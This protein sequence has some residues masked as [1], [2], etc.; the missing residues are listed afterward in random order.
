MSSLLHYR[1]GFNVGP[2]TTSLKKLPT[3]FGAKTTAG[4]TFGTATN[5]GTSSGFGFGTTTNSTATNL[6]KPSFGMFGATQAQAAPGQQPQQDDAQVI[7]QAQATAIAAPQIFND[8]RDELI[9]KWNQMQAFFGTGKAFYGPGG[10]NNIDFGPDNPWCRF[11]AVNYAR[12]SQYSNA[13][14][15]V[16][17]TFNKKESDIKQHQQQ[18]VDSIHKILGG[19]AAHSVCVSSIKPLP[20]D[21]TDM[22][23]FVQERNQAGDSRKIPASELNNFFQ[24]SSAKQQLTNQLCVCNIIAKRRWSKNELKAYLEKPIAGLDPLLWQQA[25]LDNPDPENLIPVPMIGFGELRNRMECQE[26]QVEAHRLCLE[27]VKQTLE[28]IQKEDVEIVAKIE[29]YRRKLNEFKLRILRVIVA[30][31]IYRKQGYAVQ[32]EEE[33]L[34]IKLERLLAHLNSPTQFKGRLNE[35]MSHIRMQQELS[36]SRSGPKYHLDATMRDDIRHH[37]KQQQDGLEH[38]SK[39]I[40]DDTED[41]KKIDSAFEGSKNG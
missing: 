37:L 26:Q 31:E 35:L 5:T 12:M 20:C 15:L 33:Q 3:D 36:N 28:N 1:P 10:A 9:A 41:L 38:L 34:K 30:Q 14:G 32:A 25:K 16:A 21:K 13:D 2:N 18:I 8:E 22:T 24:Q 27:G 29:E 7:L 40:R 39:V 19:N 17:L 11:K 4:L 6:S 23:I